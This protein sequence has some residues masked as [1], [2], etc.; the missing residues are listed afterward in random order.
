MDAKRYGFLQETLKEFSEYRSREQRR[1][2]SLLEDIL[3]NGPGEGIGKPERLRH[4]EE[5]LSRIQ[6]LPE[7]WRGL[8]LWSRRIDDGNRLFLI[9]HT[10]VFRFP[11]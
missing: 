9:S 6:D 3:R 1:I 8:D 10:A 2:R 5:W 11:R 4:K 7:E